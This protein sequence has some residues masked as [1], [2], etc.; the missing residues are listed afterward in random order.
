MQV[1]L[2][3]LAFSL[4]ISALRVVAFGDGQR[5]LRLVDVHQE[6]CA[7]WVCSRGAK[8]RRARE[9]ILDPKF[10]PPG[11][12]F[13]DPELC[14]LGELYVVE[15]QQPHRV[16]RIHLRANIF[17]R[18]ALCA[19]MHE[20]RRLAFAPWLHE[21][22]FVFLRLRIGQHGLLLVGARR[23]PLGVDARRA[24]LLSLRGGDLGCRGSP[25]RVVAV[26]PGLRADRRFSVGTDLRTPG[27][28][29]FDPEDCA[30]RLVDLD[31]VLG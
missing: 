21:A 9:L 25:L 18:V 26:Y 10:C 20:P 27:L 2:G 31:K 22:R 15:E 12:F 5:Q 24:V 8:L 1:P 7:P 28:L 30:R 29:A 13:G 17:W 16:N 11:L 4:C 6:L 23:R 3:E 14:P 19:G